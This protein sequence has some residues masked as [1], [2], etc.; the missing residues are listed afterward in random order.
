[1]VAAFMRGMLRK[2][3]KY[4]LRSALSENIIMEAVGAE[5]SASQMQMNAL[6][7]ATITGVIKYEERQ[8]H[9]ESVFARASRVYDLRLYDVYRMSKRPMSGSVSLYQLYQLMQ[10]RGILDAMRTD[11]SKLPMNRE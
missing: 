11:L 10:K 5:A 7:D 2:E 1:M 8:K 6:I 4:G 9:L 3:N